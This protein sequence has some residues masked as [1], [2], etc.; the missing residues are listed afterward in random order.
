MILYYQIFRN[1]GGPHYP[2]LRNISEFNNNCN[3]VLQP[4]GKVLSTEVS[5][6]VP[7][8]IEKV[9]PYAFS[10]VE[11]CS[12]YIRELQSGQKGNWVPSVRTAPFR[13]YA[14]TNDA[15]TK[16][17]VRHRC[18]VCVAN[19]RDTTPDFIFGCEWAGQLWS[20][21]ESHRRVMCRA[22]LGQGT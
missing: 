7:M 13:G 8:Y 19:Q 11:H 6:L 3:L 9:D 15:L 12:T 18:T 1:T 2:V 14:A 17:T 16:M 4:Y 5:E 22:F 21:W 10:R 20:R